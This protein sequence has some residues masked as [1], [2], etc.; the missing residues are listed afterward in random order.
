M[1]YHNTKLVNN[2]RTLNSSDANVL[3]NTYTRTLL[4]GAKTPFELYLPFRIFVL[5]D[6]IE[7]IDSPGE[8]EDVL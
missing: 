4:S 1:H 6:F 7:R 8:E 2:K 3:E 5:P